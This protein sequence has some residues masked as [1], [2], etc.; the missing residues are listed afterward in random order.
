MKMFNIAE[1][2]EDES[3][4]WGEVHCNAETAE[5][6]EKMGCL[7]KEK[8]NLK[9]DDFLPFGVCACYKMNLMRSTSNVQ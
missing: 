8:Q 6:L 9:I 7:F 5:M 4:I 3:Y 1:L 2:V